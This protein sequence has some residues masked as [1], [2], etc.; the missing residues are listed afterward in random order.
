MSGVRGIGIMPSEF[1]F[2]AFLFHSK[3]SQY[4]IRQVRKTEATS[5]WAVTVISQGADFGYPLVNRAEFDVWI[6]Y[7]T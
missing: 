6:C 4:D 1:L 2:Y 3:G 7:G 5:N